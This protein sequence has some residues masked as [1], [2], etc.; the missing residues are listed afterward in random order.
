MV[1]RPECFAGVRM[2]LYEYRYTTKAPLDDSATE[3]EQ[4][5]W[6]R[7]KF[8]RAYLPEVAA[9]DASLKQ[10]LRHMGWLE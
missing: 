8:V 4:G 1:L 9:N 7:R 6:W 2:L 5:A 10:Y 3:W